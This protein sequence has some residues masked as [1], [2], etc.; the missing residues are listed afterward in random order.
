MGDVKFIRKNGKII[1]IKGGGGTQPIAKR[2][3][4]PVKNVSKGLSAVVGG[5]TAVASRAAGFSLPAAGLLGVGAYALQRSMKITERAKGETQSQLA[6]RV[7]VGNKKFRQKYS[8][9]A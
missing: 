3:L 7:A 8:T 6:R 9:S 2:K 1:P 5:L 4:P